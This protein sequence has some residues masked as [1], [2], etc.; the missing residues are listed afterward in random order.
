MRFTPILVLALALPACAPT[1]PPEAPAPAPPAAPAEPAVAA[2]P[3]DVAARYREVQEELEEAEIE[4]TAGGGV[5]KATANGQRAKGQVG[6][7]WKANQRAI[8]SGWWNS[9]TSG[10]SRSESRW[11]TRTLQI[12]Q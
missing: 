10:P 3:E 9:T 2:S 12:P 5:V 4:G 11:H 8:T 1:V 6:A 7:A